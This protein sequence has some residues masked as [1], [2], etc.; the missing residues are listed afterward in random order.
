MIT[1]LHAYTRLNDKLAAFDAGSGNLAN[2]ADASAVVQAII[3][4]TQS[5]IK[6]ENPWLGKQHTV[7]V[8]MEKVNG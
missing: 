4:E 2:A 6:A 8:L 3:A 1:K 7:L 5:F